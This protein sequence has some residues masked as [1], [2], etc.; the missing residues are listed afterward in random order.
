MDRI[1]LGMLTPSSNTVLE[2]VTQDMLRELPQA[3]AH[4]GRFAVTRIA[5]STDAL[6]QFDTAGILAAAQLLSHARCQVIGWSGTSSS[7]LGFES[8]Q[9]L[10]REIEQSTG[11]LACTSVL[12]LNEIL[13]ATGASSFGLVTPY[14]DDVQQ[15]IIANYARAGFTCVA[16]RHLGLS[17]NFSFSD[18]TAAQLDIMIR[19]VAAARPQAIVVLCTNLRAAPIVPALEAELGI[20]IYDSVATVVWKALRLAGAD[21]R[22][23]RSWGRLFTELT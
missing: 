17:D 7:W 21:T 2:P 1:L 8:D 10:C 23:I 13:R 22:R 4:F 5:L 19:E 16:E 20:P 3:S 6:A 11:A 14:L 18:V 9:A 12:A 15:R